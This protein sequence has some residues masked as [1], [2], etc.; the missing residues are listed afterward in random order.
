MSCANAMIGIQDIQTAM[1]RIREA[2]RVSP[3][4]YSEAF[5][6]LTKMRDLS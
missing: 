3:C 4:T 6:A 2:I 5:S 1:G